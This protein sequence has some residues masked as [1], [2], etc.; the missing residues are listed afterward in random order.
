MVSLF[1]MNNKTCDDIKN[2]YNFL[3]CAQHINGVNSYLL[4][5]R[6]A[7]RRI[8]IK[9]GYLKSGYPCLWKSVTKIL[10]EASL[11]EVKPYAYTKLNKYTIG[12]FISI[13]QM[14]FNKTNLSITSNVNESTISTSTETPYYIKNRR[15]QLRPRQASLI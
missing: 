9:K 6:D 12:E 4:P 14:G 2:V 1:K 13:L 3:L 10:N 11:I 15:K 5:G 7:M 8:M